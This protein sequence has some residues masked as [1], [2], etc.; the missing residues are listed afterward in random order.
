M[1]PGTI[2]ITGANGQV[3]QH[4]LLTLQGRC[5]LVV[6]LV[7]AAADLPADRVITNWMH[8]PE[9]HAVLSAAD[10][11]V[12]LAG[13]LQ[14][15]GGNYRQAN[16][17]TTARVISALNPEHTKRVVFLSY[18]GASEQDTNAYLATK[19]KAEQALQASG[20][21]V[22]V[23]R[24]T[25]IIG[26]PKHPGPMAAHLLS[27]QGMPVTVLGT[28]QQRVAPIYINDVV[29]A[30][31]TALDQEYD[32]CFELAGPECLAI[33]D[34]VRLLNGNESVHIR[35]IPPRLARMLPWVV[36]DLPAALVDVM[37][38]DS[39]GNSGPALNAL[40]IQLTSLRQVWSGSCA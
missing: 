40:G 35:H 36:R 37:L 29:R 24:C 18:V 12:H 20:I 28:G 17:E 34:L 19:A 33:D 30:I 27:K 3:G 26:A 4:L 11:I 31:A 2:V 13:S 25:H 15:K 7:R 23:F 14:P 22:S 32:G 16:L 1:S 21:P 5:D 38:R 6:A 10:A 9:A 39:L 8:E